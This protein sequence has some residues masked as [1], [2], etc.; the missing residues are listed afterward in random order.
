MR[1]TVRAILSTPPAIPLGQR[2]EATVRWNRL[3]ASAER[4]CSNPAAVR[5]GRQFLCRC[6]DPEG[7]RAQ[8]AAE[9]RRYRYA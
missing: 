6:H 3:R 9:Q 2:C 7:L 8:R 1:A 4:Q 5:R